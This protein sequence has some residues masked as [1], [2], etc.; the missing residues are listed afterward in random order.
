MSDPSLRQ[1]P[2]ATLHLG[3][4]K[5]SPAHDAT[6]R[7]AEKTFIA[8]LN[9]RTDPS[10]GKLMRVFEKVL[11][12]ALPLESNTT[13]GKA[14]RSALWLGPDEWLITAP[15]SQ[16][17]A[18]FKAL[19]EAAEAHHV[20]IT[21][22]SDAR[23]VFLLSGPNARDVL[24]KG[25]GLDLHPRAFQTGCC[26]QTRLARTGVLLHQTSDEPA[27]DIH[28]SWSFAAYLWIWLEDAAAEFNVTIVA[29]D[30]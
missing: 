2:L 24:E 27:Y 28:V 9:L 7:L 22:V 30:G 3:D 5:T 12:F 29:D 18:L 8:K 13:N 17:Q 23:T 21:D 26:A 11:G 20:A 1:T 19:S 10:N 4:R 15:S 16:E 6:V 25:C 14:V